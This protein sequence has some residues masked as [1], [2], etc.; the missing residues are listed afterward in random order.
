MG[1]GLIYCK[2]VTG[3]R[4]LL[5]SVQGMVMDSLGEC[6]EILSLYCKF[7]CVFINNKHMGVVPLY[8][9]SYSACWVNCGVFFYYV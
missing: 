4:R 8:I 1:Q 2:R 7:V 5:A 6:G 9:Y 3:F